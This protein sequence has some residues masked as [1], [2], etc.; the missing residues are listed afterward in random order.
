MNFQSKFVTKKSLS[1]GLILIFA[2]YVFIVNWRNAK[3]AN[4][5]I[6]FLGLKNNSN[7]ALQN[8]VLTTKGKYKDGTFLGSIEDVYYGNVEVKAIIVNGNLSDILFLQY[9]NDR[10]NSIKI[11]TRAMPILKSEAIRIQDSNVDTVTGATQTSKG[12]RN[13]LLHALAQAQ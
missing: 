2:F 6:T 10:D 1:F 4:Y 7:T 8:Q 5:I 3:I 12:F 11:N 9:P 13:S